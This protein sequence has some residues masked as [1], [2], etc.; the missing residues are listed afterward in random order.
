MRHA[1]KKTKAQHDGAVWRYL[2]RLVLG[3]RVDWKE[4]QLITSAGIVY[5]VRDA[6]GHERQ[7]KTP[8]SGDWN[9]E[10]SVSHSWLP[11]YESQMSEEYKAAI[12]FEND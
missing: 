7:I 11:Q 2:N 6:D 8:W 1:M 5:T 4:S 9:P 10:S 3:E 12:P